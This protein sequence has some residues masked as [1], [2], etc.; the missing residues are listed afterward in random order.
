MCSSRL[1]IML[2]TSRLGLRDSRMRWTAF[3]ARRGGTTC[4]GLKTTIITF[5]TCMCIRGKTVRVFLSGDYEFLCHMYGHVWAV[6]CIRYNIFSTS[7]SPHLHK[8]W[9]GRHCCLWCLI[10]SEELK[11]PPTNA[12][13]SRTT[14]SILGDHQSFIA[15]GGKLNKAKLFNNCV[16]KPFF[17]SIPL[18]QVSILNHTPT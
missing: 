17:K 11:S 12:H 13:Q 8:I 6:R 14:D 15:A 7:P 16:R 10:T 5:I 2:P 18:N 4:V 3:P 1:R 9:I